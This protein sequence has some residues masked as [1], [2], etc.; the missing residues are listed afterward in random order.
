MMSL[1]R[2]APAG[3]AAAWIGACSAAV[4]PSATPMA[5]A[6][7]ISQAEGAVAYPTSTGDVDEVVRPER[8]LAPRGSDDTVHVAPPTGER[9]A[10][11]ASILAAL[12][13]IRPGGTVQFA[14]GMY[15]IGEIIRVPVN[16]VTLLGHAEGT[17][18]RGC[19]PDTFPEFPAALLACHGFELSGGHQTVRNL[20]FEYTW[21]G[22][23]I[24]CCFPADEEALQANEPPERIQPG[25][26]LVE[27]NIFRYAP[28]GIRVIGESS[29]PTV[30]RHNTF[31]DVYH[32]IGVNGR[33]VHFVD[34]HI[35]VQDPGR[36]PIS[37]HPGGAINLTPFGRGPDHTSCANNVIAGN[38]IE[39]HPEAI[40]IW[41]DYAATSCRNNTVRDNTIRVQRVSF[42][43]PWFGIRF[44]DEADSTLV[45]MPLF[46]YNIAAAKSQTSDP[47]QESFLEENVIEGNRIIGAEGLGIHLL[48][49]SRNRVANNTIS[50]IRPRDPF[51]GNDLHLG[52]PP[53]WSEANGTGILVSAGSD[54]NEIRDNTFDDVASHAIVLEGDRNRVETR[55]ASDV[56]RDLGSDNQVASS[57]T[58]PAAHEEIEALTARFVRALNDESWRLLAPFYAPDA[59]LTLSGGAVLAGRQAILDWF[60]PI[61]ARIRGV[62]ATGSRIEEGERGITATTSYT[63][64]FAPV[65]DPVAATFTNTWARQ[66]DG[67]WLI[68]AGSFEPPGDATVESHGPIRS[69]Y[70]DVD[71]ARLHYLDFGGEGIPVLF[72]S[73]GDRTAYAFMEFAP[74]FT[75]RNR[76]LALSQRGAGPSG[77][78]PAPILPADVLGR[79]IIALLDTL[80]IER[81]VVAHMWEHVLIYLAEQHPERLAGLVFLEGFPP[82]GIRVEDRLGLFGMLARN[83]AALWGADPGVAASSG[84]N[85]RFLEGGA[86]VG[87]PSLLFVDGNRTEESEWEQ[88]VEFAH[89]AGRNPGL[90]PDAEAR[91]YFERLAADEEMQE[92]G[93]TFWRDIVVPAQL[94][95][96]A[97]FHR[98]FSGS[99]RTVPLESRAIGY[100]YRDAP[101]AIDPHIRT[102]FAEVD[103]LERRRRDTIHVAPPTGVRET[104]R[105]SVL[106]AVD[107]VLPGGTVQFAPGTY[108]VGRM[109]SIAKPGVTL[110]GHPDGTTLRGC[111]ARGFDQVGRD[112]VATWMG[113]LGPGE[114][115]TS[116]DDCSI[117]GFTGGHATVRGLTFESAWSGLILGCCEA[118]LK[119]RP[120]D[121]G[122]LIESNTFR[123]IINGVRAIHWAADSTVIRRNTFVNTFH[124]VSAFGSRLHV[125]DNEVSVPDAARISVIG[126]PGFAI[127][128]AGGTLPGDT[129]AIPCDGNVI[130]GNRVEG[131]PDGIVVI[132]LPGT[133]CRHNVILDNAILASTPSFDRST[134]SG[135]SFG[136]DD[137]APSIITGVP[138]SLFAFADQDLRPGA[139]EESVVEGNS[140][141]GAHGVGIELVRASG[142]RIANNTVSDIRRRERF[143]GNVV[144]SVPEWA[145]A[146][147]SGIWVSPGSDGNEIVGNTFE[148]IASHAI[149]LEGEHN[150]VET[151]RVSD[152][153]RDVGRGNTVERRPAG[154]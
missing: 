5:P 130:G 18:I 28:N 19:D 133:T 39:G 32:A 114:S 47:G 31:I 36:V 35:F 111:D 87:V 60:R 8:D 29:E 53:G 94:A 126:Y 141:T 140:V 132:A 149:V 2:A 92:R 80:G 79:D 40:G 89:F 134:P 25:G 139:V 74:R 7:A 151:R 67:S 56:V 30:I 88:L 118:E 61:V 91:T 150:R 131:H 76:V 109:I 64:R 100:G 103:A 77:G 110:L 90:F 128:V 152:T 121:G 120:T 33:T 16:R 13:R 147:G 104:D 75:D 71:G 145:D 93:R 85:F 51:P 70:F 106:S 81:V 154:P 83:Q 136:D 55:S 27:G 38:R 23:F 48:H 1:M 115:Q 15:L 148:T 84:Y 135:R 127:A 105:A 82:R 102:F 108:I 107:R 45:G 119:A 125:L 129:A 95:G 66:P 144:G 54:E 17:V 26:H 62:E 42:A 22:L 112:M 72:I 142:N 78:D 11:R 9:E 137:T 24:G 99:L 21:H 57:P 14:P 58:P 96:E 34:N 153:V 50:A 6:S 49:A 20:T 143:P 4:E 138:L 101:D 63:A 69:G 12:E 116:M 97:A 59:V 86:V 43:A 73:S 44:S 98:A 68:V 122:Y 124:A 123:D 41:I 46:L 146:N 3:L 117:F 10:D 37:T 113:E 52:N 65:A